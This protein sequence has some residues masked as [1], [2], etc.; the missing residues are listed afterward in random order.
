MSIFG[1]NPHLF[2]IHSPLF[3]WWSLP[4]H[5]STGRSNLLVVS[6]GPRSR[7]VNS[8]IIWI[9]HNNSRRWTNQPFWDSFPC[10]QPLFPR[11]KLGRCSGIVGQNPQFFHPSSALCCQIIFRQ[12]KGAQ[13][14]VKPGSSIW[15][16]M[17]VYNI[18]KL[19]T[20][21]QVTTM[22]WPSGKHPG[23]FLHPPFFIF[24]AMIFPL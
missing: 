1:L 23:D 12:S 18:S 6:S 4:L 9:N 16:H 21:L 2:Q 14:Q 22:G 15:F 7:L 17:A 8:A 19:S 20:R 5:S 10:N 13:C 24:G 11:G 3:G